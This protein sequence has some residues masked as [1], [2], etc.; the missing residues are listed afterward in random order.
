MK[1][2][3]LYCV[4]IFIFLS[5]CGVKASI[6][7]SD[8][9]KKNADTQKVSEEISLNSHRAETFAYNPAS[10]SLSLIERRRNTYSVFILQAD[11]T[12]GSSAIRYTV[13]KNQIL[14]NFTYSP[15]GLLYAC[16]K[17]YDT[18]GRL[19]KQTFVLLTR[20]GSLKTIPLKKM[21]RTTSSVSKAS[22]KKADTENYSIRDVRFC[23]TVLA[24]TYADRSVKFYNLSE[25]LA[26]GCTD[27][28]SEA[29]RNSFYDYQYTTAVPDKDTRKYL[30]KNYD[31]R[32]GELTH[33]LT[34]STDKNNAAPYF[35]ANYRNR[36]YLLSAGGLF[37]GDYTEDT[38]QK[39]AELSF[40][41][42]ETVS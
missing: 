3:I 9:G 26:L 36:L 10:N 32:S 34:L 5:G 31:I 40:L 21:N 8:S 22:V 2:Y 37:F 38:L 33:S 19:T 14:D 42:V 29:G 23:D 17:H 18:K 28:T 27:I 1:R 12:W 4:I 39:A 15:Y 7:T 24:L 6:V 25:G 16:R 35:L 20:H 11:N 41:S 13:G 30:L